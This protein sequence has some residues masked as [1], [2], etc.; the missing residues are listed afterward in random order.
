MVARD[1]NW[2][3][4]GEFSLVRCDACGLVYLSPAPEVHEMDQFYQPQYYTRASGAVAVTDEVKKRLIEGFT[5]RWNGLSR[6][7]PRGRLLD[8]G[9]GDG[10]F[11]A[12]MRQRGWEVWG[13]EISEIACRYAVA[14]LGMP[15]E[16]ILCGDFLTAP[17]PEA[18]FDLVT[19]FDVLEHLDRPREVLRKCGRLLKPGGVLFLQVPNYGALGRRLFGAYWIHIDAPRHLVHFTRRTIAPLLRDWEVLEVRTATSLGAPYVNGYS[20]SVRHFIRRGKVSHTSG[21]VVRKE[22][23]SPRRL[24]VPLRALKLM[25]VAISRVVGWCADAVGQGEMIQVYARRTQ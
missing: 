24:P 9:C 6:R 19:L 2:K 15:V 14:T 20:D 23:D 4:P 16:R 25:E 11:L 3:S 10:H 5:Y 1:I 7:C 13:S 18:S 8:V 21:D 17:L 22:S 12:F